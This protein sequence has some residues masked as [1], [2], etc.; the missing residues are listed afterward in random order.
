MA[1]RRCA[2]AVHDPG[3]ETDAPG[4]QPPSVRLEGERNRLP[5]LYIETDDNEVDETKPS[6]NPVGTT[7]GDEHRPSEPTEPPDEK[8]GEREVDGELKKVDT[9][10]TVERVETKESR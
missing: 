7:D 9:T 5:S 6:R 1:A 10:E 3:G 4:S 2:D 8:D